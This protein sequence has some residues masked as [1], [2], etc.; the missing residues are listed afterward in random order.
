MSAEAKTSA[1]ASCARRDSQSKSRP[2]TLICI[3]KT[4][5]VYGC[6]SYLM[7]RR[8][9]GAGRSLTILRDRGLGY[10]QLDANRHRVGGGPCEPLQRRPLRF[11]RCHL[12]RPLRADRL[13]TNCNFGSALSGL[14][15]VWRTSGSSVVGDDLGCAGYINSKPFFTEGKFISI[16][17][18]SSVLD[19]SPGCVQRRRSPP[20]D[21]EPHHW[22]RTRLPGTGWR[23]GRPPASESH[24]RCL[25]GRS[26]RRPKSRS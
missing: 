23:S 12:A 4:T 21:R 5:I 14:P 18:E 19:R 15:S 22:H 25:L 7:T 26:K 24:R 16:R 17:V 8:L 9:P 11:R 13:S 20:S 10:S 2:T 1:L 3:P 6:S